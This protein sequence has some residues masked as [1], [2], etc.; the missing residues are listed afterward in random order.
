VD[1]LQ[2]RCV[3]SWAVLQKV[4]GPDPPPNPQW[5]RP[6]LTAKQTTAVGSIRQTKYDLSYTDTHNIAT[7]N[8]N[9][10]T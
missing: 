5:L 8:I 4:G 3:K 10:S 9:V 6:W 2:K 7:I 1:P